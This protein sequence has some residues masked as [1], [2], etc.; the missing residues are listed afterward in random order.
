MAACRAR[1]KSG[2]GLCMQ[3]AMPNGRCRM[4]GGKSP[5]PGPTNPNFKHGLYSKAIPARL[6]DRIAAADT[7]PTLLSH[8]RDLALLDGRLEELLERLTEGGTSKAWRDLAAGVDELVAARDAKDTERVA[9]A[10]NRIVPLVR[11]GVTEERAWREAV[12]VIRERRKQAA[13][14]HKRTL[15]LSQAIRPDELGTIIMRIA[16]VVRREVSDEAALRRIGQELERLS[17]APDIV[18]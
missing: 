3:P 11:A 7:D 9:A 1:K 5:P 18:N 13:A 10:L 15:E 6:R 8:R 17:N 4:H 14:E 12:D 2:N 16:Q